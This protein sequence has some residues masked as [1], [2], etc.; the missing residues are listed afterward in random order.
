[1]SQGST[2]VPYGY[3]LKEN[4]AQKAE[5]CVMAATATTLHRMSFEPERP[6]TAWPRSEDGRGRHG[7]RDQRRDGKGKEDHPSSPLQFPADA[8]LSDDCLEVYH[9]WW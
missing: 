5:G 6:S 2:Q 3:L 8:P 1:M 4:A 9:E 7:G